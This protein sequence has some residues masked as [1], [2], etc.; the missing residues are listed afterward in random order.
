MAPSPSAEVDQVQV[1]A[2]PSEP[3]DA[4][5]P[6]LADAD[7]RTLLGIAR[8][9]V[10]HGLDT[11]RP[12]T[13]ELATLPGSLRERRATFVTLELDGHL[14]GCIGH[15]E[16]TEP[17]ALD[18]A[19]NAFAAA[20]RDPR[21]P[22][23]AKTEFDPLHI[24][25]SVLTPATELHFANEAEL[26]AMLEPG[27]DGLILADEAVA[28]GKRGTFLPSVW[29]QLPRPRDFLRH[30]KRKAGLPAEHWSDAVRV[31]RYR[32]ESFGE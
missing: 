5:E 22:Q 13:P 31:W 7:R 21:F 32:T 19:D 18:V 9:S 17:L 15:L 2:T 11:G 10:R 4:P 24:E 25:V 6:R 3:Q 26:I 20:F 14:R 28:A 27:V 29:E 23:L 12:S 30:L 1:S 8:T 16:A